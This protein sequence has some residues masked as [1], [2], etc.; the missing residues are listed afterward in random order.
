M[1]GAS[2][3]ALPR[4]SGTIVSETSDPHLSDQVLA[5][6]LDRALSAAEHSAVDAHLASCRACRDELIALTPF[7][8]RPPVV[9]RTWFKLGVPVAALAAAAIAFTMLGPARIAPAPGT[10]PGERMRESTLVGAAGGRAV[11][12]VAPAEADTV[13]P[14]AVRFAWRSASPSATY[15]LRLVDESSSVRWTV[16]T[17]DTTV[18]LPD[19]VRLQRG[20]SYHWWVDALTADGRSSSTGVRRFRTAP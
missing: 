8:R 7:I 18:T 17:A 19:S 3:P 20:R 5:A 4:R 12:I 10:P 2:S 15:L 14:D 6:Y 11:A 16:D 1:V 13:Q 9:S